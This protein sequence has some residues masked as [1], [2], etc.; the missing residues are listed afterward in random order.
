MTFGPFLNRQPFIEL[1]NAYFTQ[2][3]KTKIKYANCSDVE[4]DASFYPFDRS[5]L[6]G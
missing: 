5:V 6:A 1:E 2:L 3:Y 4:A